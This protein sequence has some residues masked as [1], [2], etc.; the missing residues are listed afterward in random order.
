[1]NIFE[2]TQAIIDTYN[3]ALKGMENVNKVLI[4]LNHEI[5]LN[6]H[7]DK[8]ALRLFHELR[9]TLL[10]RREYKDTINSINIIYGDVA[11][12]QQKLERQMEYMETRTFTKREVD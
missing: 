3:D 6:D 1:M 8:E 5:Y 7:D 12:L 9:N 10:E 11:I 4:N 2:Q